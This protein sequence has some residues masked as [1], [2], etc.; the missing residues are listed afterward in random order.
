MKL[1]EDSSLNGTFNGVLVFKREND[2]MTS[3]ELQVLEVFVSGDICYNTWS[4]LTHRLGE[5]PMVHELMWTLLERAH[6]RD[7]KK[8]SLLRV[9]IVNL[10]ANTFIGRLFFGDAETGEVMWDCDCRPSDGCYL[11][12]RAHCPFFVHKRVWDQTCVPL[13]S[14]SVYKL[15]NQ[16]RSASLASSSTASS[17]PSS[18]NT[19]MLETDHPSSNVPFYR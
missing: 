14:S 3:D 10:E 11:S 6:S 7:A 18:S 5:R 4:L 8:W 15:V 17:G 9:A 1:F 12:L 16:Q 2:A 19:S 13:R